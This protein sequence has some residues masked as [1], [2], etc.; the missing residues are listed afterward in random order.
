MAGTKLDE[1][2]VAALI[3]NR[4]EVELIQKQFKENTIG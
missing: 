4:K 3:K 2:C 1:E